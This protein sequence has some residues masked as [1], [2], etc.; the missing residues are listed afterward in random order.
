MT[1]EG[2]YVAMAKSGIAK[3]IFY[4]KNMDDIRDDIRDPE[5]TIVVCHVPRKFGNLETSVDMAEFG[6]A[7]EDFDLNDKKIEKGSVFPIHVAKK[8][9]DV[10]APVILKRENR[11]NEDL[12]KLYEEIG[13]TRAVTGHLHESGHRANDSQGNKVKE[14]EFTDDL[15]WNSGH[16]D[17]GQT[18]ILSINENSEVRY[19]N[20]NLKDYI[21]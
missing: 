16:L 11:G 2:Q 20:I 15:F 10:G 18:G 17:V 7:A 9:R 19:R 14:W 1:S 5:K 12:K 13:I 3:G 6:E 8:I 4:Y 21:R